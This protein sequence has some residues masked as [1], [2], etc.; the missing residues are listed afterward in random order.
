[1]PAASRSPISSDWRDIASLGEQIVN[2]TSLAAQRDYIVAM[3]ARLFTG[4][5]EVWLD[6]KAFR[7]PTL[8][9][10]NVF[11]AEPELPGMQR[12][13]KAGELQTK[14]LSVTRADRSASRAARRHVQRAA[15]AAVPLIEQGVTLGVIHSATSSCSA[16]R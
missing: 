2:A 6:E 1:M 12:A 11:P 16:W 9:E 8:E 10:Q 14:Q 3:T 15:W 7:L 5:G 4:E 13:L